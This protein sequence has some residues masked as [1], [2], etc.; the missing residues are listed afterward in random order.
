M[1][2]IY[3]LISVHWNQFDATSNLSSDPLGR[4]LV[5]WN[6]NNVTLTPIMETNQLIQF[7]VSLP[8]KPCFI[9]TV[10]YGANDIGSRRQLWSDMLSI[11]PNLP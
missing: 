8:T 5:L 7:E 10:V 1:K 9:L 11:Q 4:I 6:G 2:D 3:H